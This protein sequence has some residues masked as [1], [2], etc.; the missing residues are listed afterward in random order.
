[1]DI[2]DFAIQMEHDGE[3]FYRDIAAKT[4]E[5]G[6]RTI[7]TMLAD[8]EKKHAQI[9]TEIHTKI[10]LMSGT[11][12]LDTAKNVFVQMKD[13]GGEI[14][15]SGDE[16]K[17][18]RQAMEME[19]KSVSFYLDRA[20]QAKGADQKALFEKLASEEKKHFRVLENLADLV[21]RPKTYLADAEFS[22][23]DEF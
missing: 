17:L 13:F 2:F 9:L 10:P 23:L 11:T 18:Y 21:A 14:D 20:D 16:E 8:D 5:T 1:M 12:I 3:Q 19:Q 15:L 6:I 4:S 7:M 22:N